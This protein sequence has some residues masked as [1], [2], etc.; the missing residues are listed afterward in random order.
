MFHIASSTVKLTCD[1]A[2]QVR[3]SNNSA[4]LDALVLQSA[5]VSRPLEEDGQKK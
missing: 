2:V 4:R 5:A 3:H 1:A